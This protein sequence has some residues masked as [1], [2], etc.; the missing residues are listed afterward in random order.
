MLAHAFNQFINH[1]IQIIFIYTFE[2]KPLVK[3]GRVEF[4]M[5]PVRRVLFK[6][7]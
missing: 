3:R 4:E 1:I 7:S 5:I 2:S 6:L